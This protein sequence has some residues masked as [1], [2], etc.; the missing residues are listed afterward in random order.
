MKS[1][2]ALRQAVLLG[3]R[4]FKWML[5]DPDLEPVKKL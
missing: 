3:Y 5:E 4:D 1:M 2:E